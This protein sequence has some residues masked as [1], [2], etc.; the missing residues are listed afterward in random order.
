MTP[1]N[2]NNYVRVKLTPSG[3]DIHKQYYESIRNMRTNYT[4]EPPKEDTKGFSRFQ[5]WELMSLFGEHI[6]MGMREQPFETT[7]YFDSKENL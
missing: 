2:I 1:F 7:I 4:Y 6:Y 3:K 5:L